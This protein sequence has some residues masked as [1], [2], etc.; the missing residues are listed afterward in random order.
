MKSKKLIITCED[1]EKCRNCIER[2]QWKIEQAGCVVSD[3]LLDLEADMMVIDDMK[4]INELKS[5][6]DVEI[7]RLHYVIC[8]K[9]SN[10]KRKIDRKQRTEFIKQRDNLRQSLRRCYLKILDLK[11]NKREKYILKRIRLSREYKEVA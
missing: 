5:D 7:R 8:N 6:M 9:I 11:S 2:R 4:K 1:L 3:R 10:K